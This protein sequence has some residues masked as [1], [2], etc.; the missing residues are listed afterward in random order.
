MLAEFRRVGPI[1]KH[2]RPAIEADSRVVR[3]KSF[4]IYSL[5]LEGVFSLVWQNE[6]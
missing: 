1:L 2:M 6:F 4:D 3:Q 5:E